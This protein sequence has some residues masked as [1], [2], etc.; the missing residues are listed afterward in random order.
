MNINRVNYQYLKDMMGIGER[1]DDFLI[2]VAV[3]KY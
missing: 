2:W 3:V 1:V